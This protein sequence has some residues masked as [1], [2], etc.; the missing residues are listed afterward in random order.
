MMAP[1]E[2]VSLLPRRCAPPA[3]FY[4]THMRDE[5]DDVLQSIAETLKIGR[6][7][8]VPVVISH[9]KCSMPEN[10]GRSV[11][12][13]PMIDNAALSQKVDFDIYPYA[14][15]STVLMPSRLRNDVPVQITW[16]VPHPELA[17]RMDESQ[18]MAARPEGCGRTPASG[19]GDLLSDGRA[20]CSPHHGAP[21]GDDRQ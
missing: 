11:E 14:A 20:G 15:G 1:T 6:D 8:D 9:H 5:A 17:G 21:T 10:F 3:D 13:L 18:G 19:R 4:V 2:E 16:S 7:V 12:T